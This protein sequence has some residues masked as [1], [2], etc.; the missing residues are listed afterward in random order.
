MKQIFKRISNMLF[1]N[2]DVMEHE[3]KKAGYIH[4]E[5]FLC[6]NVDGEASIQL[7]CSA[8]REEWI[9]GIG[10]MTTDR[11]VAEYLYSVAKKHD[12]RVVDYRTLD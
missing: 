1:N 6:L 11:D 4:Y 7:M 10:R 12:I 9:I 5:R 2:C 3:T 8:R